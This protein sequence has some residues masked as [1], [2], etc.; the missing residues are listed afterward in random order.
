MDHQ[1]A[2]LSALGEVAMAPDAGKA[3][4]IGGAIFRAAVIGEEAERHHREG[5]G[6]DEF[7]LFTHRSRLALVRPDL[8]RHA[9]PGP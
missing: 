7:A 1:P 6:A 9:K 5:L 8:D 3:L 4:E 2:M